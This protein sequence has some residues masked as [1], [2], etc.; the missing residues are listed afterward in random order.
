ME[1]EAWRAW[2]RSKTGRDGNPKF[3]EILAKCIDRRS[4]L[5]GLDFPTEHRHTGPNG[6][7]LS[8]HQNR[9]AGR[10]TASAS[11]NRRRVHQA[12]H[13]QANVLTARTEGVI[14]LPPSHDSRAKRLE[15]H[16][17]GH[18]AGTESD[19]ASHF[20]NRH[21]PTARRQ[22][23]SHLKLRIAPSGLY[24]GAALPDLPRCRIRAAAMRAS[25]TRLNSTGARVSPG[26]LAAD[27]APGRDLAS[28]ARRSEGRGATLL[29]AHQSAP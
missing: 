5:L 11:N 20:D 23:G 6:D 29:S 16:L 3:L 15:V 26:T 13:R 2:A 22:R 8:L 7:D 21:F 24:L 19:V 28:I 27:P 12:R 18:Q 1:E 25:R 4:K 9:N 10:G 14:A 17:V